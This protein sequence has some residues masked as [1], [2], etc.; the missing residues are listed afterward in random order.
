MLKE[1]IKQMTAIVEAT[2]TNYKSDFYRYNMNYLKFSPKFPMI[3][4][5]GKTHTYLLQLGEYEN[6]FNT[7][8]GIR[9]S[10]ARGYDG[11]SYYFNVCRTDKI[12]LID[13]QGLRE[14]TVS[15]AREVIRDIV[16]PVVRKW[17]AKNG[18]LPKN[19]RV[20]IKLH[21][22][23]ISHLKEMF[24]EDDKHDCNSLRNCLNRLQ[25]YAK[26]SSDHTIEVYYL[27]DKEHEFAFQETIHGENRLYGHI[28]FH[29]YPETGYKCNHSVQISPEYGWAS[30]T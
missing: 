27:G 26:Q 5:V 18:K 4:I 22:I 7:N 30:H 3:W 11:F 28:V 19:P 1:L 2:M 17:E 14:I 24:A 23:S 13:E 25:H 9:Y 16:T 12:Y 8:E 21:N 6:W 15:A 29:G 20:K 10:Y